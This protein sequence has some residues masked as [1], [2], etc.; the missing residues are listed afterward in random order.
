M[1]PLHLPIQL[2]IKI[3]SKE[4]QITDGFELKSENEYWI[5]LVLENKKKFVLKSIFQ[6]WCSIYIFDGLYRAKKYKICWFWRGLGNSMHWVLYY[7]LIGFL[8]LF[9]ILFY[10]KHTSPLSKFS[11]TEANDLYAKYLLK[12]LPNDVQEIRTKDCY[13]ILEYSIVK[14]YY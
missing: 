11:F 6:H 13:P 10:I 14:L 3:M 4:I 2:N 1:S 8:V 9:L 12:E 5:Y 7:V